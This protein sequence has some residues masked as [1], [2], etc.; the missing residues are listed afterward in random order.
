MV[1]TSPDAAVFKSA[2]LLACR[3]PAVYNSQPWRW[4]A[5]GGVLH[6]FVD[7][8]RIAPRSDPSGREAIISC[9]AVLGHLRVAMAA[10]GWNAN[11]DRF[12]NPSNLDHLATIDFSPAEFITSAQC[13]RAD[14]ILRRGT[15]RLPF[16][17]PTHWD[18]FEPVLR[19]TLDDSVAILD[20]IS[21]DKRPRLA[22]A[23]QLSESFRRDDATYH[24]ELRWWTS[25]SA[26]TDGV[27]P[28][29]VV[30]EEE[31]QRVDVG[32]P[33]PTRGRGARRT[34]VEQDHSKILVLSTVEDTRTDALRCG[35]ALS[36]VLLECTMAGMATCTLTH[37]TEVEPSREIVRGLTEKAAIPQVLLRV[38]TA[39]EL[40]SFPPATPRRALAD[41]LEFR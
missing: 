11:V 20:V 13:D 39:P 37:M 26:L 32:R 7:P 22:E 34:D 21:D 19:A 10:A 14:A 31:G 29:A 24:A 5:E 6:L 8:R 4:V 16:A 33:F 25:P 3:A 18:S 36:T 30:S 27:P 12:P 17:A 35:E 40:D 28:S 41:V 15:D 1:E 23:S 9:G 2:L 38:G